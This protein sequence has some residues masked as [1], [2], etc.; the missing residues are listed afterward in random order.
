MRLVLASASPI[1]STLLSRAGVPHEALPARVDEAAIRAALEAE[2]AGPRDMADALAEAKA[3]KMSE[4]FPEAMVIGCDQVL[5]LDHEVLAK[6]ETPAEAEAQ[7]RRLRG[8]RH[9]LMSAAVIYHDRQP[10]WRHVGIAHL[11]MRD[12]SDAYLSGYLARNRESVRE[13]VGAYKLE[14]E[15]VRLFARVEGEYFTVLG[16][17]LID[18]LSYL[19][20]RGVIEG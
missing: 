3:R 1:R 14:E 8:R 5:A 17:P 11:T 12:F 2:G 15:G 13:S 7:L 4:K 6:P 10:Q 18:I 20:L 19:S 16:L 9:A